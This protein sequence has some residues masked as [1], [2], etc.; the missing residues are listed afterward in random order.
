MYRLVDVEWREGKNIGLNRLIGKVGCKSIFSVCHGTLIS[1]G[2]NIVPGFNSFATLHDQ[3]MLDLF[4]AKGGVP[5]N[6]FE[7]ISSMMPSLLINYGALYEKYKIKV[8]KAKTFN[9][10]I[11]SN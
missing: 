11:R 4:E 1:N 8:E 9:K 7:N 10:S 5:M 3:W 6:I 2:L